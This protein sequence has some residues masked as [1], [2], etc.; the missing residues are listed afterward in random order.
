MA[1]RARCISSWEVL[2]VLAEKCISYLFVKESFGLSSLRL[3]LC[4]KCFVMA[5]RSSCISL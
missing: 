1:V 4:Q 3:L 5:V 2:V